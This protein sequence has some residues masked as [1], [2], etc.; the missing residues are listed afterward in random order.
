MKKIYVLDGMWFLFRAYHAYPQTILMNNGTE[1][2]NMIFGFSRMLTK[3]LS[4]KPD[5]IVVAR[6]PPS[7][8]L[9][10]S[11]EFPAYKAHRTEM[12]HD[13]KNQVKHCRELCKTL[14]LSTIEYIGYEADDS[15]Y[16]LAKQ[17]IDTPD[18]MLMIY[19]G[20]KDLKQLLNCP[21]V[22]IEDPIKEI[23]RTEKHF[24][25]EFGFEPEHMVDYLALIGD[26]SDNVP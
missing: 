9:L 14:G 18:I 24:V 8:S 5:N 25:Q 19:T 15:I 12:P 21:N 20:D 11:I 2:A 17:L 3:L 22:C 6:D 1:G 16:T 4:E 26:V 7:V 23:Q 10:R 13:F